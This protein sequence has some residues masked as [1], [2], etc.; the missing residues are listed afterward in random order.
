MSDAPKADI[1][2]L[3]RLVDQMKRDVAKGNGL[4]MSAVLSICGIIEDAIGAPID[5][6]TRVAGTEAA[7]EYYPGDPALRHGF[8]AGVKWAVEAYRPSVQPSKRFE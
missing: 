2:C 6:P 1:K 5:W 3:E 8:N 4:S 7:A